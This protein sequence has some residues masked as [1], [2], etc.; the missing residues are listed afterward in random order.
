M[1]IDNINKNYEKIVIKT[2]NLI[3]KPYFDYSNKCR[4]DRRKN[5]RNTSRHKVSDRH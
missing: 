2:S 1:C 4:I 3:K 5:D